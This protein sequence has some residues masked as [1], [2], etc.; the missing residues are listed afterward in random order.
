MFRTVWSWF[1][2]CSSSRSAAPLENNA[3]KLKIW[4][5]DFLRFKKH[6]NNLFCYPRICA[7]QRDRFLNVVTVSSLPLSLFKTIWMVWSCQKVRGMLIMRTCTERLDWGSLR[8]STSIF[9]QRFRSE[10]EAK[11]GKANTPLK[12]S[13]RGWTANTARPTKH[14][15]RNHFHETMPEWLFLNDYSRGEPAYRAVVLLFGLAEKWFK[16]SFFSWTTHLLNQRRF[17]WIW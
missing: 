13:V 6:Y 9:V 1:T 8:S 12:N 5:I 2:L 3:Q 15:S 4:I 14:A 11:T 7:P 10:R 17:W 16:P